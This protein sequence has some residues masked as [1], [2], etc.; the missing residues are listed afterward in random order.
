MALRLIALHYKK[1]SQMK[2]QLMWLGNVIH[3]NNLFEHNVHAT[4]NQRTSALNV[5]L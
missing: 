5:F 4:F 2:A 3:Q 1:A